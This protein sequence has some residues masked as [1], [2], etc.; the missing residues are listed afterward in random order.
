MSVQLPR[1]LTI[2]QEQPFLIARTKDIDSFLAALSPITGFGAKLR[3]RSLIYRGQSESLW[4]LT[5]TSRRKQSWPPPMTLGDWADTLANRLASEAV[6]LLTYCRVADRQGLAIPNHAVLTR[7]LPGHAAALANRHP[8]AIAG[9]PPPEAVPALSLAQHHGLSTCLLDFTWDPYVAAYF[10]VRGYMDS[11]EAGDKT[12][13]VWII[14]DPNFAMKHF[15]PS[16]PLELLV[17]PASDNRTLQ[18]QEGLFMWQRLTLDQF[19][20]LDGEYQEMPPFERLLTNVGSPC[21]VTKLLL[22][23]G[24]PWLLL[25]RLIKLGYD[26]SRLFPGFEGSVKAV[27][28]YAWGRVGPL[29]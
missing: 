8:E 7:D 1:G 14:D 4:G 12:L 6:T 3:H 16:H 13:C 11:A 22:E 20:D 27:K 15:D 5:P 28:E 9:W 25:H 17:P 29:L 19:G 18:A 2:E 23:T 26:G 24:H 21:R 10:A